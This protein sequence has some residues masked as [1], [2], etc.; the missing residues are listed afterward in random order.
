MTRHNS[1]IVRSVVG[2]AGLLMASVVLVAQ[3]PL[4]WAADDGSRVAA[5]AKD[6]ARLEGEHVILWFPSRSR[7]RMPRRS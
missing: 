1:G 3:Q 2:V 6:G 4:N 7:A 5:L